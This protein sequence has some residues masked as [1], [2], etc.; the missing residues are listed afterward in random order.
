[1]TQADRLLRHFEY[2]ETITPHEAMR[3]YGIMRLAALVHKLKK[4]GHRIG[5][6]RQTREN[7]FGDRVSFALYQY[8][9]KDGGDF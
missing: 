4:Q 3:E 6:I 8:H 1:M 5:S 9:G 2:R 7:R